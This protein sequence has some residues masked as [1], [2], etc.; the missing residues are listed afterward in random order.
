LTRLPE[1]VEVGSAD[2]RLDSESESLVVLDRPKA[3]SKALKFCCSV[4]EAVDVLEL[5]SLLD[6]VR[7]AA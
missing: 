6:E 1:E 5:L 3:S 7:L 2:S 4:P